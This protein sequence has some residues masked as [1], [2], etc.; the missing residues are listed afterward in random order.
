MLS[1]GLWHGYRG[2]SGT[3]GLG[4]SV[5]WVEAGRGGGGLSPG[6]RRP[7]AAQ[8]A[9]GALQCAAQ[10]DAREAG[11]RSDGGRGVNAKWSGGTRSLSL[12][13]LQR[14]D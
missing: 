11:D 1:V 3:W 2:P 12:E 9:G 10:N 13:V 14:R 8:E 7:P 6:S 5:P 4:P